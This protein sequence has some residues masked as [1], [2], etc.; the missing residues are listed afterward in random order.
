MIKSISKARIDNIIRVKEIPWYDNQRVLEAYLTDKSTLIS[1]KIKIPNGFIKCFNSYYIN[2]KHVMYARPYGNG[3]VSSIQLIDGFSVLV[4]DEA[5]KGI[6]FI[7]SLSGKFINTSNV[8]R[9]KIIEKEDN[10]D[11]LEDKEEELE[12]DSLNMLVFLSDKNVEEVSFDDIFNSM[13]LIKTT[14]D[15]YVNAEYITNQFKGEESQ[16]VQK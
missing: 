13:N 16:W 12:D 14:E 5:L 9:A 2:P 15:T 8:Q 6:K 7:E 3:L 4:A 11:K 1:H 10:E